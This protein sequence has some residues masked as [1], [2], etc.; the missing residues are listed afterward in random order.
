MVFTLERFV[1]THGRIGRVIAGSSG[2]TDVDQDTCS[3][4]GS[5][6]VGSY[7]VSV[8]LR[9]FVD[10]NE[11]PFKIPMFPKNQRFISSYYSYSS[12]NSSSSSSSDQVLG[13]SFAF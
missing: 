12:S 5:R 11:F 6:S 9:R 4:I 1:K 10:V 13:A 7:I 2:S 8:R 3:N